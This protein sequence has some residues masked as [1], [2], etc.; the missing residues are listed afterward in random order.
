MIT[1]VLIRIELFW[2]I[3]Q[4]LR[5]EAYCKDQFNMHS[6]RSNIIVISGAD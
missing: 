1:V 6:C 5:V 2:P 4:K 3:E